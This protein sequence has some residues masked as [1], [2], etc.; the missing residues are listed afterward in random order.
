MLRTGSTGHRSCCRWQH[1]PWVPQSGSNKRHIAAL[2][3]RKAA[4]VSGVGLQPA[5][6][7]FSGICQLP[8]QHVSRLSAGGQFV[9][10][11]VG[12]IC[13]DIFPD[14][15]NWV[16]APVAVG[17]AVLAMQITRTVHPPGQHR[18][19]HPS[20]YLQTYCSLAS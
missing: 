17:F 8:M 6:N 11:I 15:V 7:I 5:A 10:S 18:P 16:S 12:C 13:R 19:P 20:A 9:S 2:C 1:L 3:C 14:S 4:C